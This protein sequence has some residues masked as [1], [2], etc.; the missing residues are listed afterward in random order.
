MARRAVNDAEFVALVRKRGP[1]TSDQDGYHW[2]W[3]CHCT[4][5]FDPAEVQHYDECLWLKLSDLNDGEG[6]AG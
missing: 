3:Y 2:C 4:G 1:L 6:R 5:S